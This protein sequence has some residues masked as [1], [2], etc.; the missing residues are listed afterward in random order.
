MKINNYLIV[1]I[2]FLCLKAEGQTIGLMQHDS[3]TTDNGYV[4]FSPIGSTKTFLIDKCGKEVHEWNS[5]YRPGQAVYLLPNGNLLRAG[6]TNNTT[7]VSGGQGG[8]IEKID[9]NGNVLWNYAISS[10][11]ECQH[12]DIKPLPN[13][14]ILAIVWESKTSAQAIAEGRDPSWLS[15]SLWSE[16]IIEIQPVGT[17]SA[18]IVWEWHVWDHLVQDFD[19]AK[20]NYALVASHP[21]LINLNFPGT[22]VAQNDW[23]HANSIDY[24]QQLDQIVLS[25][26]NFSEIWVIDHSTN[27][28]QAA[29]H[30]GGISGKGGDLLYRW[31]NPQTYDNGI[32]TDKK[33]FGQHNIHWITSGLPYAG[34][35]MIFNNG[36][37]RPA[38]N[39][40]SIDIISTPVDGSGNYN[41]IFPYGP[42]ALT[43]TYQATTPTDF[44]ASNISGA[45]IFENG[46]V[47]ICSGTNGT[48]FEIDS[49]KNT[50]WKYINP[51][52]AIG[53]M[54]QGTTPT[55]NQ[56]FRAEFYPMNFSG[57]V[58][59]S[60]IAGLQLEIN[61]LPY[62]CEL[63]TATNTGVGIKTV[64]TSNNDF[65]IYPNPSNGEFKLFS[66]HIDWKNAVIKIYDLAGREIFLPIVISNSE[67]QF[68]SKAL[69]SGIYFI[70]VFSEG[71]IYRSKFVI[72]E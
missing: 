61:P 57:F 9:W 59:H 67:I 35:I 72:A 12:H 24:N 43:W 54:T 51:I 56:C 34:D 6:N 69:N 20:N 5:N 49:A 18:N 19:P 1:L 21:E 44:Y 15:T 27:T 8:I 37:N 63:D 22:G 45:Q 33:L 53:A 55:Q 71:K 23:L 36:L 66:Q 7:F 26:H 68:D 28:A 16:K 25:S 40:S 62:T 29:S 31:G 3:G 65:I 30:S 70:S 17:D 46:N 60:L 50:I 48:Y 64:F 42:S 52:G 58:G 10:D 38:G 41:Q 4:L 14:N 13:G 2:S 47:E 32:P 11:T 39:F